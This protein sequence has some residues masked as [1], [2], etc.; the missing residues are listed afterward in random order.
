M[1]PAKGHSLES[2]SLMARSGPP[3]STGT[4]RTASA[5]R[6]SRSNA[7]S[8]RTGRVRHLVCLSNDGYRASLERFKIYVALAD[9]D[10]DR[11][12]MVRVIDESGED[13]LYPKTMFAAVRVSP[14]LA[15]A[16]ASSSGS[17]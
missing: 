4:K 16:I 15:R 8:R 1:A 7:S 17:L 3:S 6:S 2:S 9:R 13:Y 5:A 14:G 10:A 12:G 11:A